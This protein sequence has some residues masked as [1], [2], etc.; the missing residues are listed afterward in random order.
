MMQV[1]KFADAG[2][3]ALQH[4]HACFWLGGLGE[5][6]TEADEG[7]NTWS[8]SQIVGHLVHGEETD[9]MTP[10]MPAPS[11]VSNPCAKPYGRSSTKA[12]MKP[13]VAKPF[14]ASASASVCASSGS[15]VVTLSRTPKRA[16]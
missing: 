6:W 12:P 15:G 10:S 14:A 1:V 9:W 16:G 3:A 2:K 4:L 8:A 13:P 5:E 7:P 11:N